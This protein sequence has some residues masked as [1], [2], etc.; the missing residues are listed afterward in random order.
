MSA[1][2]NLENFRQLIKDLTGECVRN[3]VNAIIATVMKVAREVGKLSADNLIST[4][5]VTRAQPTIFDIGA[6]TGTMTEA[7][8][9]MFPGASIHAFEPH[10]EAFAELKRKFEDNPK[11]RLNN[12]GVAGERGSLQFN[13]SSDVG[14]SSFLNYSQDSPYVRGIGV[15]TVRSLEIKTTSIDDYCIEHSIGHIDFIKLDVQG[16]E[17]RVLSG[18]T[19]MLSR[20]AV[21]AIQTEIVFR[22][23]Y[24][25]ASS[26]HKIEQVLHDYGYVLRAIFDIYPSEGAQIFQC[27]AIYSCAERQNISPELNPDK[28]LADAIE[29]QRTG[30]LAKARALYEKLLS[31]IPDHPKILAVA[32]AIDLRLGRFESAVKV[33]EKALKH[34]PNSTELAFSLGLAHLS[35]GNEDSAVKHMH[36]LADNSRAQM[37]VGEIYSKNGDHGAAISAFSKAKL[38]GAEEAEGP[39]AM[40]LLRSGAEQKA[41]ELLR[42]LVRPDREGDRWLAMELG[43]LL[44]HQGRGG[45][46]YQMFQNFLFSRPEL[47]D[48]AATVLADVELA[49]G[50]PA[51]ALA[52]L[53]QVNQSTWSR[54][55]VAGALAQLKILMHDLGIEAPRS[56]HPFPNSTAGVSISSLECFGRFG[57][58]MLEYLFLRY[59][60]ESVGVPL[61]TPD[62]I[63]HIL[64]DINDPYPSGPRS[65]LRRPSDWIAK[66]VKNLGAQALA[67]NDFFSPGTFQSWGPEHTDFARRVFRFR[68][69]WKSLLDSKLSKLRGSSGTLVAIHLRRTDQA[70]RYKLPDNNWYL[71]WLKLTWSTLSDPILYLASDDLDSVLQDFSEFSPL[72]VRD[73]PDRLD[74]L[75]WLHDFHLLMN[76]DVVAISQSAF[77][78]VACMLNSVGRVFKQPDMQHARLVD[79]NPTEHNLCA[80]VP[81]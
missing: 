28:I 8:L 40:A 54:T 77:S 63:G 38:A 64:F 26:F 25:Q 69:P 46:A 37:I 16:F 41:E 10:P 47:V 45:E 58:Q 49:E 56:S 2:V 11:V 30:E 59:H 53:K 68:S 33:L 23:F 73:F 1:K 70:Q 48:I 15:S 60:A 61:E 78:F 20:R 71:E 17:D 62:W 76:A 50:R 3:D 18:A 39:L 44:I 4:Q 34:E 66:R 31:V 13:L 21:G 79:Y 19:G 67:G 14:S 6:N 80:V 52:H 12:L 24:D 42:D 55:F 81:A 32:G 9:Q 75:D 36:F 65:Q 22:D 7:Y 43:K 57:H 5:L 72:S 51:E 74:G 29:H 27:D 35:S